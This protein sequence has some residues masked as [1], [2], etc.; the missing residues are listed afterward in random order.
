MTKLI[1]H[2]LRQTSY[3]ARS[4]STA[5]IIAP[6]VSF[7]NYHH[8][9][10]NTV[11]TV[12]RDPVNGRSADAIGTQSE[13]RRRWL[14]ILPAVFITYSLAYL[15]RTNYG[16]GAAA[17][18]AQTL[19]ISSS[20]SALLGALFFFGYFLF[21]IPGAAY[22]RRRSARRL[23]FFALVSWGVLA[24]LTGVIHNFWLLAIDRLLLGAAESFILPAMLILLTNW[25]TRAERSRTN[26]LLLLGNPVTVLWMSAATG[27]LI[28]AVGWQM[29]FIVEGIPSI[30]WGFVWL[31]IIRDRP[32]D[33][34]WMSEPAC[35]ELSQQLEREQWL[36]PQ[37]A[38]MRSALRNP[39]VV[40]L[41][42]QYFFWS[43][44]VYGFVIWLPSVVQKGAAR[45]IGI[46]GLLSGVPYFFAIILMLLVSHYSDRSFRRKRFVWPFLMLA[47]ACLLGSY[48]TAAHSFW[49][50]YGFLVLAGSC[51]YAPYGP[52]FA[53]MPEMLSKNVAGEV[54]ALVNSCGALGGFAGTWFVGLLEAHTGNSRA[55]FLLMS[56]SLIVS[57]VIILCLRGTSNNTLATLPIDV[58][59]I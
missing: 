24:S 9:T 6:I 56:L 41:S 47:G 33:A 26:T 18:L 7:S 46:T 36:L 43:L 34:S 42:I 4:R 45:G 5:A 27:Y 22:A 40:W 50:A 30:L 54:T 17:G 16:F 32:Q 52:F 59:A 58:E 13:M 53:I 1:R 37:V 49:W 25:F 3:L 11:K 14:Y 23:I 57:S 21:Q 20:R 8:P 55:G 12:T 38:N 31:L 44:G 19:H 29:T 51:M 28:H 10:M 35:T 15:D 48:L 39:S 2:R